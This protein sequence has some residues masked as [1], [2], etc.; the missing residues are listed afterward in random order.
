MCLAP[1]TWKNDCTGKIARSH[2]V[3][4]AGSLNQI[5][6]NG[7]VYAIS[8]GLGAYTGDESP[9]FCVKLKGVKQASTFHGFCTRH[10]SSIFSPLETRYFTAS[11]EQ[12]FLLGFRALSRELYAKLGAVKNLELLQELDKGK[13]FEQQVW[14]QSTRHEFGIDL[15]AGLRD[16]IRS[17]SKYDKILDKRQF[18]KVRAYVIKL[19]HP[20]PVMCSGA[21]SPEYDFAGRDLQDLSD[22]E[23]RPDVI[24]F[25]S[26][27]GGTHG[28]VVFSWLSEHDSSCNTF[29]ESLESIPDKGVTTG[30]IRFIFDTFENFHLNPEWWEGLPARTKTA[31]K[32]RFEAS[33]I[34]SEGR[35][36][37]LKDDGV[38]FDPWHVLDRFRIT[39]AKG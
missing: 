27:Y 11:A 18:E 36:K 16:L 30:L 19:D 35:N 33:F 24:T 34:Y 29:I 39:K 10:D 3:P 6:R 8:Y 2:T 14:I 31:L 9:F 22:L 1:P 12:C 23:L 7:H 32:A 4:R 17:K 13:T 21:I 25:T 37:P 28:F 20:P 38:L 5:S 15:K 26:F